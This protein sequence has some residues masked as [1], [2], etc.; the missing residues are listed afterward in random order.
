M[1]IPDEVAKN[2]E[3]EFE[4]TLTPVDDIKSSISLHLEGRV[5][6]SGR[7]ADI[8]L[9]SAKIAEA[10]NLLLALLTLIP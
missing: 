3:M 1:F 7:I 2:G 4:V 5:K 8:Y 6:K 10:I 9:D